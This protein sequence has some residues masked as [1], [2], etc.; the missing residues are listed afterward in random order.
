MDKSYPS[1][2]AP[3]VPIRWTFYYLRTI[4]ACC[5]MY[6]VLSTSSYE[7]NLVFI[8]PLNCLVFYSLA[9][10]AMFADL[11]SICIILSARLNMSQI[12]IPLWDAQWF[13]TS[14]LIS[15]CYT[16]RTPI[17]NLSS[18]LYTQLGRNYYSLLHSNFYGRP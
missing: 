8:P 10:V 3:K 7:S 13:N 14:T 1:T 18:A 12:C 15:L 11:V 9:S 2:C 16:P 4:Q 17:S 6:C 5:N